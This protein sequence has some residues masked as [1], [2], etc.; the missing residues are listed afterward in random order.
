MQAE[1]LSRTVIDT[2]MQ[3]HIQTYIRTNEIVHNSKKIEKFQ[4]QHSKTQQKMDLKKK[5][6]K[7]TA[8]QP[9]FNTLTN[10]VWI[11][12]FAVLVGFFVLRFFFAVCE[13][14]AQPLLQKH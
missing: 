9:N 1:T 7:H 2:N 13:N 6:A 3:T 5:I 4:T 14:A 8:G 10:V 12:F 11:L